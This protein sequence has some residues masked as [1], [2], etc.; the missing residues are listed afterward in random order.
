[1]TFGR[2]YQIGWLAIFAMGLSGAT[3]CLLSVLAGVP[4]AW[5]IRALHLSR[6]PSLENFV[7]AAFG[8]LFV[9]YALG[10]GSRALIETLRDDNSN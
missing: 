6:D 7:S 4:V 2:A 3:G 9:P 1:V 10:V 8:L 5:I